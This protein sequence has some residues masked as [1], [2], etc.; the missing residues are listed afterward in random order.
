MGSARL[1]AEQIMAVND[2]RVSEALA[3]PEWGGLKIYFKT[4]TGIERDAFE[5][6]YANEKMKAFRQRFLALTMCDESGERIF[7]DGE[8]DNL[9]K[10]SSVVLNRLF[11]AAWAHNAFRPEDVEAAGNDS[12]V[13]PSDASISA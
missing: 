8:V 3:V 2:T 7:T 4:L 5:E 9:G 1:L 13:D 10:K 11:D 12:S 6:G